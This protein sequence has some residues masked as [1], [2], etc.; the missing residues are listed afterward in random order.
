MKY[1]KVQ[2]FRVA[3][4]WEYQTEIAVDRIIRTEWVDLVKGLLVMKKGFCFEPSGPTIKSK[5]IMQGCCAHD[6]IYYLIRNG[7]LEPWWKRWADNLMRKLHLKDAVHKLR[8]GYFHWFVTK[9]GDP[10]IDPRNRK[11]IMAAP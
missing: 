7:L 1:Q 9:F 10:A 6:A 11:K 8:A 3:V 5:S 2:G 4:T